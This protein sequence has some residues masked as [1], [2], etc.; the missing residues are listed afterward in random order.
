M[1]KIFDTI[2]VLDKNNNPI[3]VRQEIKNPTTEQMWFYFA[4]TKKI[5]LL[6][7]MINGGSNVNKIDTEGQ[8]IAHYALLSKSRK[9]FEL[10]LTHDVNFN[11]VDIFEVNPSKIIFQKNYS[12]F[13]FRNI[14][15]T[16]DFPYLVQ[17]EEYESEIFFLVNHDSNLPKIKFLF[18][19]YPH[20]MEPLRDKLTIRAL[21]R[22]SIETWK[23]LSGRGHLISQLNKKLFH[24]EK[25]SSLIKI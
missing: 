20:V 9:L 17:H 11:V 8:T 14:I 23:Y 15:K 6:K 7:D 21:E 1:T 4:K 10:C 3:K 5:D 12:P 13:F 24:K 25:S 22:E 18:K 2:D 16:L 19:D